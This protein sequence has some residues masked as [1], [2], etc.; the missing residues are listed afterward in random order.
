MWARTLSGEGPPL[1]LVSCQDGDQ[2]RRRPAGRG[3]PADRVAGAA[4]QPQGLEETKQRVREAA[5]ALGYV[6]SE[7]GRALS[8]G[9]TRRIGLLLT[10]LE[11]QFYPHVIAPM[12]HELEALGYQLVLQTETSDTGRWPSG[13]SPTGST[14]C[15]S[16][17]PR[18]TRCSRCGCAT[19]AC[20][21]STSTA[22]PP[23]WRP[24][25]PRSTRSRDARSWREEIARARAPAGR[26]DLRTAEHQHRR[27][28]GRPRC[29]TRWTRHGLA[30]PAEL[31][32]PRAVRLRH[33]L[34]RRTPAAAGRAARR[35]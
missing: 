13:W 17:P 30:M 32:P 22:P 33:R 35:R 15:C 31:T 20:R 28:S 4:R 14:A 16:P 26:R 11:N 10:D 3:V 6:P 19:A 25:R 12:H 1:W 29:A 9:R 8:S 34:R 2:P 23:P 21:S 24:T 18:S 7:T 5:G 27:S